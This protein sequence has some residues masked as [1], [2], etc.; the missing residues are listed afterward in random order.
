M[1]SKAKTFDCVEMK[2]KGAARLCE[3]LKNMS[4]EEQ[5]QFWRR[6]AEELRRR[7]GK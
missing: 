1:D 6:R 3:K 4:P 5:I 7:R 2:R